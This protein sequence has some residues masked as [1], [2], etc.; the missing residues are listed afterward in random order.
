M[1]WALPPHCRDELPPIARAIERV[2]RRLLD[3]LHTHGYELVAPSLLGYVEAVT[4]GG[5]ADLTARTFAFTDPVSGRLIGMRA[6][7]TPQ[8]ARLDAHVLNRTGVTRLCYCGPVAHARP[9]SLLALREPWQLGAE[10]FGH[11]GIEADL[12]VVQLMVRLLRDAGLAPVRLELAHMGI[13]HE[14]TAGWLSSAQEAEQLFEWLCGKDVAELDRWLSEQ[15]CS[16]AIRAA[17]HWLPRAYGGKEVLSEAQERLPATPAIA[18]ALAQLQAVYDAL[19]ADAELNDIVTV[20]IDLADLR[21]Y[22]YHTGLTFAAFAPSSA[23]AVALGG[24]YDAMGAVFGRERFATGFSIDVRALVALMPEEEMPGAILAP[25][26][27]DRQARGALQQRVA[28]LRAAGEAVVQELPGH[29]PAAWREA[30]CDRRLVWR[31]GAWHVE[32]WQD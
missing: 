3:V 24:R 6:D 22:H 13:F 32:A 4:V 16:P 19:Y 18:A 25:W 2:R 29:P 14:L 20:G 26:C 28:Q 1:P 11:A 12:E 15:R 31:E 23:S 9:E 10:L 17:L 21:G 8:V 7:M 27:E 30:G 5:R